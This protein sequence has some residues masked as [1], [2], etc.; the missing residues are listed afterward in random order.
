[1]VGFGL[2]HLGGSGQGLWPLQCVVGLPSLSL[3]DGSG[4]CWAMLWLGQ[5]VLFLL[6][7][8]ASPGQVLLPP[9]S[10]VLHLFG[11]VLVP[12]GL[13]SWVDAPVTWVL[14]YLPLGARRCCCTLPPRINY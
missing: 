5:S 14:A 9:S 8:Q 12:G 2:P 10:W 13:W 4:L 3:A 7:M 6:Q 11:S 1:M